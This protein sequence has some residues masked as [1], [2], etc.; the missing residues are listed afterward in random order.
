MAHRPWLAFLFFI[1]L[2]QHVHRLI[3][4]TVHCVITWRHR[5]LWQSVI[6]S[7]AV[8]CWL[9]SGTGLIGFFVQL[10]QN[11]NK[12]LN[13]FWYLWM[14]AS[15]VFGLCFPLAV[16]IRV[17]ASKPV[18]TSVNDDDNETSQRLMEGL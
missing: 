6:M 14:F 2:A 13:V 1:A 15:I 17:S 8:V 16:S 3:S 11:T 12:H 5:I 9:V 10:A 4:L 18:N 7:V